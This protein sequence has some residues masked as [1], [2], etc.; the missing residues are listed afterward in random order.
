MHLRIPVFID[1]PGCI[2]TM[3]DEGYDREVDDV[4]A[5]SEQLVTHIA[6]VLQ[7][8]PDLVA[9]LTGASMFLMW[10]GRARYA[11]PLRCPQFAANP[12]RPSFP[13]PMK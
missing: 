4:T 11:P 13:R 3:A 10:L 8:S 2:D 12:R 1:V 5:E 9:F 7:T 6:M